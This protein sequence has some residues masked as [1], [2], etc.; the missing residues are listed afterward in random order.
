MRQNYI[1]LQGWFGAILENMPKIVVKGTAAEDPLAHRIRFMTK[2]IAKM[3][4][5]TRNEVIKTLVFHLSP[6]KVL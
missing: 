1:S 5:E 6:P 3:V 2:N 4:P